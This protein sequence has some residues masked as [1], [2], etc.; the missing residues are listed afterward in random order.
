MLRCVEQLDFDG[1]CFNYLKIPENRARATVVNCN[2]CVLDQAF[3]PIR[4]YESDLKAR[5]FNFNLWRRLTR[6]LSDGKGTSL[7]QT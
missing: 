5:E 3:L 7:L 1:L 6:V 2:R 4:Q